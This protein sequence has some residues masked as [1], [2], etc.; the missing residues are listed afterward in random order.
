[1]QST[2]FLLKLLRDQTA[3]NCLHT[4]FQAIIFSRLAFA[5]TAWGPFTTHELLN[6]I[7]AILKR[8]HRYGSVIS[9]TKF[10]PLLDSATETYLER[11]SLPIPSYLSSSH[12][13]DLSAIYT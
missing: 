3:T 5:L 1:M 2:L 12:Q 11:R 8:S 9:L 4:V 13:T 10:Q 6:K 7:V